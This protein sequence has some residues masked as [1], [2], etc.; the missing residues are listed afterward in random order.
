MS[1]KPPLKY[2]VVFW[3]QKKAPEGARAEGSSASSSGERLVTTTRG[4]DNVK[5]FDRLA[6][7][8]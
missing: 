1:E 7:F 8:P 5:C 6:F 3:W 4:I 2:G